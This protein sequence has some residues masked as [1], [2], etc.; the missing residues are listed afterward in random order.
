MAE[1]G[2]T[3]TQMQT[4]QSQQQRRVSQSGRNGVAGLE[5]RHS[6]GKQDADSDLAACYLGCLGGSNP[7]ASA[8]ATTD[9]KW[10]AGMMQ[11]TLYQQSARLSLLAAAAGHGATMAARPR[12][13]LF[14]HA[15]F[16]TALRSSRR[17]ATLDSRRSPT[18]AASDRW[19]CARSELAA[20]T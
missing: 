16:P 3:Q 13:P 8:N 4:Q 14:G 20:C 2:D 15:A 19:G 17:H 12:Q 6:R 11:T 5:G 18:L 1:D 10:Q 7:V 9:M